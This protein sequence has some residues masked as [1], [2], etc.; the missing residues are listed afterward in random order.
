MFVHV[1]MK[2]S[3]CCMFVYVNMKMSVR[4]CACTHAFVNV[5]VASHAFALHCCFVNGLSDTLIFT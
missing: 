2:M 1:N 5:R 4:V 3:V